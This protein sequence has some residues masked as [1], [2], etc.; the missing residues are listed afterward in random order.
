MSRASLCGVWESKNAL[1]LV[2]CDHPL[3]GVDSKKMSC[4]VSDG[5]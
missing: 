4:V 1:C 2:I 5:L 3:Y